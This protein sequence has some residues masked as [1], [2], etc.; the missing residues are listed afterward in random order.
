MLPCGSRTQARVRLH[1]L[2]DRRMHQCTADIARP[3][4]MECPHSA[5][6]CLCHVRSAIPSIRLYKCLNFHA[7]RCLG[8]G[9]VYVELVQLRLKRTMLRSCNHLIEDNL[10][11]ARTRAVPWSS[12]RIERCQPLPQPQHSSVHKHVFICCFVVPQLEV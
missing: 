11:I 5:T 2:L 12:I 4:I 7:H 10:G 1:E 3:Q 6:C 9:P 8:F